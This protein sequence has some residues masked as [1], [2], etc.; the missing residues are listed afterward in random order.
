MTF[1][2][3]FILRNRSNLATACER[4]KEFLN[5]DAKCDALLTVRSMKLWP[6]SI[7]NQWGKPSEAGDELPARSFKHLMVA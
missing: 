7:K 2:L 5:P 3:K 6:D 1:Y 4:K